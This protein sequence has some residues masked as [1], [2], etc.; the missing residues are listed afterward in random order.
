MGYGIVDADTATAKCSRAGTPNFSGGGTAGSGTG[1]G[2]GAT[3]S[4]LKVTARHTKNPRR[5]RVTIKSSAPVRVKLRGVAGKKTT[6]GRKTVRLKKAGTKRFLMRVKKHGHRKV[7]VRWT[8]SG[9][10]GSAKL[11]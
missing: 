3:G 1:S 4:T 10:K 5:I 9:R 6:I 7:V 2:S 8:A 11:K